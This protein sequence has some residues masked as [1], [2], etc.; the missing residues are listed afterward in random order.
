MKNVIML[1]GLGAFATG[2]AIGLQTYLSGRA[3]SIVGP[4]NTGLWT[5]FLGGILA[6]LVILVVRFLG[7]ETSSNLTQNAL[8][9]IILSGALGILI[10]TGV[11]YSINLA[12]V[13]AGI[14]A[15][16]LGQMVLSAVADTMGW[17]GI[18]P[19]PLD[20]RRIIGLIIMCISVFLLLPRE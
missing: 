8:V 16:F 12:G 15:M 10:I 7:M 17:G 4:I 3:G 2:I 18:E 13:T 9:I 6:G 14:A 5:N 20:F 19:I 1:G 11:A